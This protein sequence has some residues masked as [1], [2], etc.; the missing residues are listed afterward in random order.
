MGKIYDIQLF[1]LLLGGTI[2]V[3]I[4][5]FSLIVNYQS[6]L[7]KKALLH[8]EISTAFL[9]FADYCAY[10]YR[11]DTSTSGFWFVHIGNFLLFFMVYLE[12]L[13]LQLYLKVFIQET[14]KKK[15][16]RLKV[17]GI[18]SYLG[19]LG[20]VLNIFT[21]FIY[22]IND[23]NLYVRGP[24]FFISFVAPLVIY[25]IFL[26]VVIEY[27]KS[28]PKLIF[29]ALLCFVFLPLTS[30][31]LQVFFYGLSLM[32]LS[33][34]VC[35]ILLF[36]LSL[37]SQN[38]LLLQAASREKESGLPNS[39]GFMMEV[40]K[41]IDKK[42]IADYDAFYF[43]IKRMG[44]IN[45]KYGGNI[46]SLIIVKYANTLKD[47]LQEDEIL[48]RLG[49]NFFVALIRKENTMA[50]LD[51]LAH[52]E[53]SIPLPAGVEK[54]EMA[55]IAG[56]Y[57]IESNEID[58]N[59]IMN[60]VSMAANIAKHM[61]HKPYVFLTPELQ[62]QINDLKSLQEQIPVSMKK[63][64]F[65][66][67]YQPKVNVSDYSLCGAEA[68]VRWERDDKIIFPGDFIPILEQNETICKM[69]F[70][71][72]E[73]VCRDI[74]KWLDEGKI[75]PIISVNFSR[76]NLG[77]PILA[78]EIHNVL[79]KYEIPEN[80]IQV[81][82]TE[83]I[84]EYP[85]DYLKGVVLALQNYGLSAALDDFGTG[86]ASINLIKEVPFNVLKID[87]SFIDT[88]TEKDQKI[89]GHIISIANEVG[90]EVLSEGVE[91]EA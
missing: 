38:H 62:K 79:K 36:A 34:C 10:T 33:I 49:G 90:S 75:P 5:L 59:Q 81:E 66:P 67:Y 44:M 1:L 87:K 26:S 7:K 41:L 39:Y 3:L 24:L 35:V 61:M 16:I 2:S 30:S 21:G 43:D 89:L 83:T 9:L 58:T 42:V 77:N 70:Y 32:N 74:R 46:G 53:I 50:F 68:L 4:F 29:I 20:L 80:L 85:L 31:I 60:N 23:A 22:T 6:L 52:T 82:I 17:T 40:Q 51:R 12:L 48:G 57:G 47:T 91:T 45:R 76:K 15:L 86:S 88:L 28:F 84:D 8:L 54:L 78:E 72:L 11:G 14:R 71:M 27:R 64:E 37:I 73:Y 63:G 25:F 55:S 19:I 18:I 56:V 13:G 65:K 69:D